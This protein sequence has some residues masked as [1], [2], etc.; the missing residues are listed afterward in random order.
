M[1]N[2]SA[3]FCSIQ[4]CGLVVNVVGLSTMRSW[5]LLI[6]KKVGL[7]CRHHGYKKKKILHIFVPSLHNANSYWK[8]KITLRTE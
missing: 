3:S 2:Y 6:K 8:R 4:E 7:R 5:V 1:C